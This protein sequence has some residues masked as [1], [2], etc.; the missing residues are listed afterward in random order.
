[1]LAELDIKL[2]QRTSTT[3]AGGRVERTYL[4]LSTPEGRAMSPIR[5]T[6]VDADELV[7]LLPG[8]ETRY[9]R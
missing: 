4:C 8:I 1:M 5:I 9:E 7:A 6:G 2:L 3:K